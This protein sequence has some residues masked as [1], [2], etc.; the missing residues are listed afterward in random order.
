MLSVVAF[1]V[2]PAVAAVL[3]KL[4]VPVS[5]IQSEP[6]HLADVVDDPPREMLPTQSFTQPI[7][8]V[9]GERNM[10]HRKWIAKSTSL[11]LCLLMSVPTVAAEAVVSTLGSNRQVLDLQLRE[12]GSILGKLVDRQGNALPN[13]DVQVL[14]KRGAAASVTTNQEG[15]FVAQGLSAGEMT[16]HIGGQSQ[17][18]R[19]WDAKLAPPSASPAALFVVGDAV[20]GQCCPQDNCAPACGGCGSCNQCCTS[21]GGYG[22]FGHGGGHGWGSG[23]G[24]GLLARPWLLGAGVAAAIAIPL[25]LDDDDAS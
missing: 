4:S 19:V 1:A 11:L 16:V 7:P 2:M 21:G 9:A 5:D 3:L 23:L 20:R 18:V 15:V 24:H 13:V 10:L 14:A 22:L 12:N 6:T 25:A 8:V 17:A